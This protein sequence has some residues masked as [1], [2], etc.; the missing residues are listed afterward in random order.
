MPGLSPLT[1][2][3]SNRL[4]PTGDTRGHVGAPLRPPQRMII[5]SPGATASWFLFSSPPWRVD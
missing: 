3:H 1:Q 2:Y 4:S 5:Y